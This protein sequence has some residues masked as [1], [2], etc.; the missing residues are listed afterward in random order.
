MTQVQ[1]ETG[2]ES[3]TTQT[4]RIDART[5]PEAG[6]AVP[7]KTIKTGKPDLGTR[8][9][10]WIKRLI[11]A[12]VIVTVIIVLVNISGTRRAATPPS[13]SSAEVDV[14][15]ADLNKTRAE[16][17]GAVPPA[18][19]EPAP[20]TTAVTAGRKEPTAA[21]VV[22][23]TPT[24]P[25]SSAQP[26]PELISSSDQRK[27]ATLRE[28]LRIN[29][30]DL[31]SERQLKAMIN[32][33]NNRVRVALREG[34]LTKAEAYVSQLLELAPDNKRLEQALEKIREARAGRR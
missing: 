30:K 1:G 34:D 24:T 10:R 28:R 27:L 9:I 11:V 21:A 31:A 13:T 2:D 25:Q 18:L 14:S 32:D 26:P 6:T 33:Y 7:E 8:Y 4:I 22:H 15:G 23:K 3:H 16:D 29:P 20:E 5:T 19:T 17:A 12:T